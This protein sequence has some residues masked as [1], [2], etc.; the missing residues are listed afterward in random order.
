MRIMSDHLFRA[1]KALLLLVAAVAVAACS[2][3][4]SGLPDFERI[5]DVEF[6]PSLG[7]DLDQMTRTDLGVF[8]M[9][10]EVGDGE[11]V[12]SGDRIATNFLARLRDGSVVDS[13]DNG[14]PFIFVMDNLDTA[15][16]GFHD[17]VRGMR[18]GGERRFVVPPEL[19][20]NRR[21]IEGIFIFDVEILEIQ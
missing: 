1:S 19:A 8:F 12:Q 15:V 2:S 10:L 4:S 9:D 6:D 5:E 20:F 7:I 13:N 14:E 17:G 21:G 18:V 11:E 3:D 16:R